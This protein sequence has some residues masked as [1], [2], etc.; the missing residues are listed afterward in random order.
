MTTY[1]IPYSLP[2]IE[3]S[4]PIKE[5]SSPSALA[6]DI[7]GLSRAVNTAFGMQGGRLDI[8]ESVGSV[9]GELVT[10]AVI[11]PVPSI[12]N[13]S[14]YSGGR[15]SLSPESGKGRATCIE[16][17]ATSFYPKASTE[18]IT[19]VSS[20]FPAVTGSAVSAT[21]TLH[22]HPTQAMGVNLQIATY[23]WDGAA[24]VAGSAGMALFQTELI[25]LPAGGTTTL[26]VAGIIPASDTTHVLPTVQ[27]RRW[28]FTYPEV[29]DYIDW[30]RFGLQI[31]GTAPA[32]SPVP[33]VDGTMSGGYWLGTPHSSPSRGVFPS[34]RDIVF[35][36]TRRSMLVSAFRARRGGVIGTSGKPA[37]ALRFDH[38]VANFKT[39][40]LPLLQK[41]NLPWSQA[42]NPGTLTDASNS[43]T[44][45]ELQSLCINN[46]G[47]VA[48][49]GRTHAD[50]V[51]RAAIKVE[52]ET[53][54]TELQTGMTGLAIETW[55]PPGIGAGG[56]GGYAPMDTQDK[57]WNTYAGQLILSS[58]PAVSGYIPGLYRPLPAELAIGLSHAT[59]DT[60]STATI[61]AWVDGAITAGAGIQLMLHPALVDTAGHLT[62]AQLETALAYIAGR[63]DA[64]ALEVLTPSGLLLADLQTD[65]RHNLVAN[66]RFANGLTSWA[67]TTGWALTTVNGLTYAST[68]T[69]TPLTQA[70]SM[71]RNEAMLGGA[72]EL[73]YKVRAAAGAVVRT[74]A[75]GAAVA[76]TKDHTLT[77][78]PGWREVR[79][80]LVIPL[81]FTGT[82]TIAGGRVSG[83]AV[84]ITDIRLQ[85]I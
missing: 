27:Y 4:D 72:R 58:H 61:Q 36:G 46:G 70:V 39:K 78:A 57:H 80:Q 25:Q 79:Q 1:T 45:A 69:G 5:A 54:L 71:S 34:G 63:R 16:V 77:A 2:I 73:V 23:R 10:N 82:L 49:H 43:T 64:G 8:V 55:N 44:F 13:G 48:N 62:T 76:A 32:S 12:A 52:I 75:T 66:G 22:G 21:V 9:D 65:Q 26:E 56:Y 20:R 11:D 41:Y 14:T 51:G 42:V 83:G 17:G 85:T 3:T 31:G 18:G 30:T 6:D 59:M 67:N 15:A 19:S 33:Y 53:S 28:G 40:V 37:L 7:N 29:G 84:D 81:D 74:A 47:E 24:F 50:A 38:G 35:N 60:Q 68:S